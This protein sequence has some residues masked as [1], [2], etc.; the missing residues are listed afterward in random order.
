MNKK[1]PET[2]GGGSTECM[3]SDDAQKKTMGELARE[4]FSAPM[5]EGEDYTLRIVDNDYVLTFRE[6]EVRGRV[7]HFTIIDHP[8]YLY[9]QIKG[10]ISE[11]AEKKKQ[12][13]S[14]GRSSEKSAG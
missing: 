3:K 2:S 10:T 12:R 13:I 5:N 11:F 14:G 4:K 7:F 9:A 6:D 1:T 8:D